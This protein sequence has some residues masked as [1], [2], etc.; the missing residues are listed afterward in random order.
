MAYRAPE[1]FDVKTGQSLDEKVDIWVRISAYFN[2]T[3]EP[4]SLCNAVLGVHIVRSC[5]FS[6]SFRKHANYGTRWFNSDGS[7]EC[8]IQTSQL[9]IFARVEGPH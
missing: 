8:P 4:I 3:R 1:L 5:I 6:F 2:A 7:P 9:G